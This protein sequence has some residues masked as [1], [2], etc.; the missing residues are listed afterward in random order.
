[1]NSL[2]LVL[3]S[4][5]RMRDISPDYLQ[6]FMSYIDTLIWL[7]HAAPTKPV[8]GRATGGKTEKSPARQNAALPSG[9]AGLVPPSSEKKN[10]P[11][12]M[13][14]LGSGSLL[15]DTT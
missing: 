9:K 14:L 10:R 12:P 8:S 2:H 5:A 11:N 6:G 13:P 3:R 4:L 7:E 15:A 1:M